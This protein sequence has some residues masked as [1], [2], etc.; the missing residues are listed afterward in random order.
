V[1]IRAH[2][3]SDVYTA[4]GL[5]KM[6][7]NVNPSHRGYFCEELT[8]LRAAAVQTDCQWV[9]LFATDVTDPYSA[10]LT[11]PESMMGA[12][13]RIDKLGRRTLFVGSQTGLRAIQDLLND[14]SDAEESD[15]A[16]EEDVV[17]VAVAVAATAPSARDEKRRQRLMSATR[18][19]TSAA[20]EL[21]VKAEGSVVARAH[22]DFS[23]WLS[24]SEDGSYDRESD[25]SVVELEEGA[26]EGA[27]EFIGVELHMAA[28][29]D[30]EVKFDTQW[31]NYFGTEAEE[32]EEEEGDGEEEEEEE[33][34]GEEEEE[35]EEG[36]GEEG[37][38]GDDGEEKEEDE[39]GEE[40]EESE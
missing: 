3:L 40:E 37:E 24:S 12:H 26:M 38:E 11:D 33:G 27:G 4:G 9:K 18:V 39:D 15:L 8:A 22:D 1:Q 35:E 14:D 32:K 30:P 16:P 13:T 2:L 21:A 6:M 34:D 5:K 7:G 10:A 28:V 23:M 25:D 31:M 20:Q 17:H 36:D 29:R 19:G